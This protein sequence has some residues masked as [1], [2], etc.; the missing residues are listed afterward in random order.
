MSRMFVNSP[1]NKFILKVND[2]STKRDIIRVNNKD[3]R[4]TSRTSF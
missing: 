4:K 1:V 3:P 2:K